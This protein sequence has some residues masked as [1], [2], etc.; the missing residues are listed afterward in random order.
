MQIIVVFRD[1]RAEVCKHGLNFGENQGQLWSMLLQEKQA[2]YENEADAPAKFHLIFRLYLLSVL[3]PTSSCDVERAFSLHKLI[4]GTRRTR[5]WVQNIDTRLRGM[6]QVK[7]LVEK[8]GYDWAGTPPSKDKDVLH[9]YQLYCQLVKGDS[10]FLC[11]SLHALLA[12][13]NNA[14]WLALYES[15]FSQVEEEAQEV[16]HWL[17]MLHV[18]RSWSFC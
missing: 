6:M 12:K 7:P 10:Q 8:W 15:E 4:L 2:G 14:D 13:E 1:W 9:P 5:I 16:V 18:F 3:I 11:V 17:R